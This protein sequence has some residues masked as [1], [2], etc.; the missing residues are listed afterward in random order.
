MCHPVADD[1]LR[2]AFSCNSC[3]VKL[4]FT[5][6]NYFNAYIAPYF[7]LNPLGKFLASRC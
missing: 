5:F 2:V 4:E 1:S 7:I 3:I 6:E